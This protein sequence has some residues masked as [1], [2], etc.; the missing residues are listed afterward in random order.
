M[1]KFGVL[2]LVLLAVIGCGVVYAAGG[3]AADPLI[4]LDYYQTVYQPGVLSQ[5]EDRIRVRTQEIYDGVLDGLNAMHQANLNA[6]GGTELGGS[7]PAGLADQRYK[8]G[9]AL[10]MDTGSTFVLLAGRAT[11]RFPSGTVVDLTAGSTAP[12]GT[13]LTRFHRYLAAEQTTA[14]VVITSETAV[15]ST[16][17]PSTLAASQTTD[18]NQ[19]AYALK[20]MGLFA[21]TDTGYGEG[22]D[23][24]NIPTRI[25]GLIMFL[26]LIGEESAARSYTGA[27]PFAD[28]PDWCRC[29]VAYA[30]S[31]GYT[32]GVGQDMQ[33][34]ESFAPLRPIGAGEYLTFVMRALGYRDSGENPDFTW[35]NV[36]ARARELNLITAGEYSLFADATFLRA[37]VAY[38][39]YFALDLQQKQGGSLLSALS[40]SGA[41]DGAEAAAIRSQVTVQRVA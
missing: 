23:L 33:G 10:S 3:L 22:Y 17:G 9:D 15:L 37:H 6:Q 5:A 26:R 28:V 16:E 12:S 21:G 18:Y 7:A 29:Y 31:K 30:Y 13:A 19:L 11:V 40:A 35:Q 1:K 4:T 32:A 20:R 14:S 2:L 39:S 24:E 25:E 34:R 41:L 8:Q 27:M 38:C 36:L